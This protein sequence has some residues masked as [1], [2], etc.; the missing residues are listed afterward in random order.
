MKKIGIVLIV[1][2]IF[3]TFLAIQGG[4]E[5]KLSANLAKSLGAILGAF[6]LGCVGII[7][8]I[9]AYAKRKKIE[10]NY[11]DWKK[12]NPSRSYEYYKNV[13]YSS[14]AD[15]ENA[16][17]QKK[18]K[19]KNI[20]KGISKGWLRLHKVF[21]VL[22]ALVIFIP[23]CYN[24]PAYEEKD[25]SFSEYKWYKN[26][27]KLGGEFVKLKYNTGSGNS[28]FDVIIPGFSL[29]ERMSIYLASSVGAFLSYW[30]FILIR[31][32]IIRGFKED[33]SK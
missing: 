7:L 30:I 17:S 18:P 21:S 3:F 23:I 33:K 25:I 27:M 4:F 26:D 14:E 10:N 8:I 32:W 28:D 20:F 12:S 6:P 16:K 24:L 11:S 15:I 29:A 13:V 9:L 22:F 5:L 1:I 2:Q 19:Q 31:V